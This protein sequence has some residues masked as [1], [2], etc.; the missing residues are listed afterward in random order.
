MV[1]S[2]RCLISAWGPVRK[3][4]S[5]WQEIRT[6]MSINPEISNQRNQILDKSICWYQDAQAKSPYLVCK[7]PV[8]DYTVVKSSLSV[9]EFQLSED[10]KLSRSLLMTILNPVLLPI[11]SPNKVFIICFPSWL[12]SRNIAPKELHL[13]NSYN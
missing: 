13:K 3:V 12:P 11:T 8:P 5:K 1:S 6:V 2:N 9:K 10:K 4:N 7:S